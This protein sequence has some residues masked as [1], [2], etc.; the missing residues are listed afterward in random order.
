MKEEDFAHIL[1]DDDEEDEESSYTEMDKF[2]VGSS[3]FFLMR[4]NCGQ[5]GCIGTMYELWETDLEEHMKRVRGQCTE[6]DFQVYTDYLEYIKKMKEKL[7]F[8]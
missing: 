1:F 8:L 5:P 6:C 3:L 2:R 4:G 7:P